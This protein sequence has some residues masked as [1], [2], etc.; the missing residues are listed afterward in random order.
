M[1]M[2]F[3]KSMKWLF[4]G[5]NVKLITST[6]HDISYITKKQR[7]KNRWKVSAQ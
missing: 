5:E 4:E 6:W 7:I 3:S 1:P 2:T